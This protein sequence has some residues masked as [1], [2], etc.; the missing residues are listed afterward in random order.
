MKEGSG[1]FGRARCG[2]IAHPWRG[3][4]PSLAQAGGN[5]PA[6][7]PGALKAVTSWVQERL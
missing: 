1:L 5:D 4:W 3:R 6:K 7:L 2:A